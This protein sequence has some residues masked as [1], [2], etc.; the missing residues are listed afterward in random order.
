VW[1]ALPRSDAVGRD[2]FGGRKLHTVLH[3]DLITNLHK[4]ASILY[5]AIAYTP[6]IT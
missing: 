5:M 3:R 1:A 4:T 6:T 2:Q